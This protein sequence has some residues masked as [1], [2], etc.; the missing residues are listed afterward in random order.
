ML[1][2][3]KVQLQRMMMTVMVT[4]RRICVVFL[5]IDPDAAI[6]QFLL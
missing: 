3:V 5:P 1:V 2:D 4:I 6:G